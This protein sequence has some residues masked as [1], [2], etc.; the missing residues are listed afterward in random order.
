MYI[1]SGQLVFSPSDLITFMESE[2]ASAMERLK[3]EDASFSELMDV[4]NVVLA[5][6]QKKGYEHEDAFTERLKMLG[7]DVLETKRA[8]PQQTLDA[9]LEAMK[10]GQEVITQGYLSLGQFGGFTDYLVRVRDH[11]T[12]VI[13]T[14]RC[15]TRN[16]QKS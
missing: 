16:S 7:K 3:L 6:L 11:L 8:T 10:A 5:S 15:G 4:E 14:M 2:Y 9:T 13:I 12:L 1:S